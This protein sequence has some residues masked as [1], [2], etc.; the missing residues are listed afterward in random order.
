ME[1]P[2]GEDRRRIELDSP[3]EVV[4]SVVMRAVEARTLLGEEQR[5]PKA[6]RIPFHEWA[7]PPCPEVR[8]EEPTK[9]REPDLLRADWAADVNRVDSDHR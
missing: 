5:D 8:A 7:Q 1:D 4:R 6:Q 9:R 3:T 2:T